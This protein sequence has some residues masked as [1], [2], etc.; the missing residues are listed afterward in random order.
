V[1]FAAAAAVALAAPS[2]EA[3]IERWLH[4]NR[5]HS[6]P[7]LE[8]ASNASRTQ[9]APADLRA[10][11]Q[12]ELA[13]AG[14]YQLA[15]P[16]AVPATEPWW[17]APW[18]W[19]SEQW[20]RL[21]RAVFA[22]AHVGRET[23]ASIGDVLLVIVGLI[24]LFT[25]VRL[26]RNL[27]LVRSKS[28]TDTV[29][30]A[31]LPDPRSLYREACDAA[32]RGEYGAAALLLFAAT[33]ALL[34]GRGAVAASHSATVGDLRRELRARDAALIAPFDA[35]AA[36]FVQK[37][38]AERSVDEPQWHR[39]RAAFDVILSSPSVILSGVEGRS[40]YNASS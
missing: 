5:T 20:D 23:A 18:R 28:R 1:I 30:L 19:L 10:L 29:P 33:V 15:T 27:Q 3:L 11:A 26:L 37:A 16:A 39:A 22:R 32:N 34:D 40:A 25:A 2:R 36:P 31:G 13:T 17:A 12:R 9:A 7:H 8:S 24:L 38:Y 14:R 4:A 21:W 6:A 35:V